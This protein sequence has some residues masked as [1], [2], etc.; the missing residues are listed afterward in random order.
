MVDRLQRTILD[1]RNC[2]QIATAAVDSQPDLYSYFFLPED[3]D[4]VKT[5]FSN[6]ELYTKN[7]GKF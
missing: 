3:R 6:I 5:V 1:I 2:A 4:I 7:Q